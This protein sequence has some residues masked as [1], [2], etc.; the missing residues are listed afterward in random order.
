MSEEFKKILF[1]EG[2]TYKTKGGEDIVIIRN[3]MSG[4]HP[5]IGVTSRKVLVKFTDKGKHVGDGFHH[6]MDLIL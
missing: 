4:S 2:K 6:T 5:V 3:N 1:Q